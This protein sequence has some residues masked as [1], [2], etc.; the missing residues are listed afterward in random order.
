MRKHSISIYFLFVVLAELLAVVSAPAA[1]AGH[2]PDSASA[3][4]Q[5]EAEH[6]RAAVIADE[7]AGVVRDDID[8]GRALTDYGNAGFDGHVR[9][10]EAADAP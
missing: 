9:P 1:L 5:D 6:T 7:D 2:S 3:A 10:A 8:Y 4:E